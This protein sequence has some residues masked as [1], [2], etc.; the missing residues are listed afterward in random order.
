MKKKK[1]KK[2]RKK[3]KGN[4]T[5]WKPAL[6]QGG[7]GLHSEGR[8]RGSQICNSGTFGTHGWAHT[9]LWVG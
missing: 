5:T 2:K 4:P 8:S 6:Y 9:P 1:R 7:G 3:E